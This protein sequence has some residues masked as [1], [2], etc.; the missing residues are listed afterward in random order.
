MLGCNRVR[1]NA[2]TRQREEP[3]TVMLTVV[4][5]VYGRFAPNFICDIKNVCEGIV[6][7]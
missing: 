2:L 4:S 5:R 7:G 1:Q 6:L 3:E